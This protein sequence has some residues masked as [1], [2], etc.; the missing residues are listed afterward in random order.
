MLLLVV[1]TVCNVNNNWTFSLPVELVTPPPELWAV[2]AV[3]GCGP[4]QAG[5]GSGTGSGECYDRYWCS[6]ITIVRYY[7][8]SARDY[9]S[10]WVAGR[11][12]LGNGFLS[13]PTQAIVP[14]IV[15]W[16]LRQTHTAP[17]LGCWENPPNCIMRLRMGPYKLWRGS[18]YDARVLEWALIAL[19]HYDIVWKSFNS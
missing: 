16:I 9:H 2:V 1:L 15:Q 10:H 18:F 17:H 13:P 5:G 4:V 11:Q 19:V 14:A 3:A 12:W 8:D 6:P 7:I